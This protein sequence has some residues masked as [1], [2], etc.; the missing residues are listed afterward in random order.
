MRKPRSSNF[1]MSTTGAD[2]LPTGCCGKRRM[3]R[4][5]MLGAQNPEFINLSE[6]LRSCWQRLRDSSLP[7]LDGSGSPSKLAA[8]QYVARLGVRLDL[9]RMAPFSQ[10]C[11]LNQAVGSGF[12]T[13]RET[14][15]LAAPQCAAGFRVRLDLHGRLLFWIF[16]YSVNLV[17]PVLGGLEIQISCPTV[18]CRLSYSS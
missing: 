5:G 1:L 7:L 12:W 11:L 18:R 9:H 2:E 10:F 14:R 3:L 15:R 8:P 16:V 6:H 17:S 4:K 13:V